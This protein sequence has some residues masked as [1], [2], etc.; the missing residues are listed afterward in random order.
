MRRGQCLAHLRLLGLARGGLRFVAG[1]HA[2]RQATV[3]LGQLCERHDRLD[4]LQAIDFLLGRGNVCEM[5]L[6]KD[7]RGHCQHERRQHRN[8][9]EFVCKPQIADE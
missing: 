1:E 5:G 7:D 9:Q 8:Q 2:R 6:D 4:R 3:L